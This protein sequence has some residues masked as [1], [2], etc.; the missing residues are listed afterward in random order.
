MLLA[1]GNRSFSSNAA[2]DIVRGSLPS[3]WDCT[4]AFED[5]AHEP[6][7]SIE[8]RSPSGVVSRFALQTK[9]RFEPRDLDRLESTRRSLKPQN[10][11]LLAAP[12][13]SDRSRQ[14]LRDSNISHIDLNGNLW[15]TSD[16]IFIDK[17]A[18]GK[19]RNRSSIERPRTSLRGPIT[20]RL[21]RFLCDH[22][23][24]FKVREIA[25]ATNVHPGNI[26]RLMAFLERD[27]YIDRDA[28]GAVEN[29]DW[30]ALLERWSKDLQRDRVSEAFLEPRGMQKV[31]ANLRNLAIPYA[32][33]G[34]FASSRLAPLVEPVS[35]DVYVKSVA[36][37]RNLLDL[38]I[39]ERE[40]IGNVR[41]VEAF[42]RVVF[43]D[44][45]ERDGIILAAPTQIAADL[46]TMPNRS[47]DENAH[48]LAW[49]KLHE[50]L[51][52]R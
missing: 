15:I 17:T 37:A 45:L 27:R 16:V 20:G 42:D 50:S 18:D 40:R 34:S 52:K 29:V 3:G 24:P 4:F 21:V 47:S 36:E 49:M 46:W 25:M 41:L 44:T 48:L 19:T 6:H 13:L 9:S 7:E 30:E 8:V 26:S 43:E 12:F 22:R 1:V 38:R 32:A 2:I 35:I 28:S 5:A 10:V 33:T 11:L 51:W 39:S 31:I 23:P 14:V